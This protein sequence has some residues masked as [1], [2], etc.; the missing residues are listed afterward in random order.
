MKIREIIVPAKITYPR[1]N[2]GLT[3]I[4]VMLSILL[5]TIVVIGT[6]GYRYYSAMD[7]RRAIKHE[8]AARIASLLNEGWRGI[9]PLGNDP[10]D[11]AILNGFIPDFTIGTFG[12][13]P[14]VPDGF[15]LLNGTNYR[16]VSGN[17]NYY[18]TMSYQVADTDSLDS[19]HDRM[20]LNIQV[21]WPITTQE[22]SYTTTD[23]KIFAMTT[24]AERGRP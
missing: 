17:T 5:L 18:V 19:T 4:E 10:Y 13:G 11:P 6:S 24:Y 20:I 2:R 23:Y 14:A 3:L 9:V 15:E 7:A 21:A 1:L 22:V 16:V 12:N 8:T